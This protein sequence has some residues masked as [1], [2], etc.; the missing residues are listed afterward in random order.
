MPLPAFIEI[1]GKSYLWRDILAC[2]KDQL[3]AYALAQQPPL[4]ELK[5][6][7]RPESERTAAGRYPEASGGVVQRFAPVRELLHGCPPCPPGRP[8]IPPSG[9]EGPL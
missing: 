5:H 3:R 6:D 8:G 7:Q 9:K 1:D 2:R 4:F